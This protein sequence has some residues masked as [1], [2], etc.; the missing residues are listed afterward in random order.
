VRALAELR[1]RQRQ[2][3]VENVASI[4]VGRDWVRTRRQHSACQ[5]ET[6]DVST[7]GT[8][9]AAAAVHCETP[10]VQVGT[11]TTA[12]D[13]CASAGRVARAGSTSWLAM[14]AGG[15]AAAEGARGSEKAMPMDLVSL[16][17][18]ALLLASA[19]GLIVLCDR[20]REEGRP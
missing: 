13:S 1:R 5:G 3:Q 6:R 11:R 15:T 12:S 4:R 2:D 18:T 10:T 8:D 20:L 14:L 16:L 17:L 19:L 9:P 7:A